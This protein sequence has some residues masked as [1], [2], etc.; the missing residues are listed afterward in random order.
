MTN[1]FKNGAK[2]AITTV[3]PVI[4]EIQKQAAPQVNPAPEAV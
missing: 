3:A 1:T 2:T 4:A